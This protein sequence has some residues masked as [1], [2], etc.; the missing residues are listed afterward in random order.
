MSD[1]PA[2]TVSKSAA[3]G[4]DPA[5]SDGNAPNDFNV[6]TII[7][8]AS[9]EPAVQAINGGADETTPLKTGD[10]LGKFVIKRL[11]GRGGMGRVYLAHDPAIDREVAI[12]VLAEKFCQD[13]DVLERFRAEARSSGRLTHPNVVSVY[14]IGEDDCNAY[15]AMEYVEGGSVQ[16]LLRDGK[17]I[18]P[19]R[20]TEILAD[21]CAGLVAAH[22]EGMIHR[23]IKPANLLL[24]DD[25]GVKVADFGLARRPKS[26]DPRLTHA[27]HIV[28]TPYY[29]SPEQCGGGE[30]DARSDIYSMGAT[31]HTLLTGHAPFGP[32]RSAMDVIAAHMY[33]PRPLAHEEVTGVP[34]ICTRIVHRAMAKNPEDRYQTAQDLLTDAEALLAAFRD[35]DVQSRQADE[36]GGINSVLLPVQS[37]MAG[38]APAELPLRSASW[39]APEIAATGGV[40]EGGAGAR[41]TAAG[42]RPANAVSPGLSTP[43][44]SAAVPPRKTHAGGST[45]N[46][47]AGG[48]R[49]LTDAEVSQLAVARPHTGDPRR[50][51]VYSLHEGAVAL[52]WPPDIRRDEVDELKSWLKLIVAKM[53]RAA[54]DGQ[55][56]L[57]GNAP[58]QVSDRI[59]DGKPAANPGHRSPGPPEDSSDEPAETEELDRGDLASDR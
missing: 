10:K 55:G 43:A 46:P 56:E 49:F 44:A 7:P 13:E 34:E 54:S 9:P 42:G 20:A 1:E 21:A 47:D 51:D 27:A 38:Q 24:D 45:V 35:P 36:P 4:D 52:L 19:G 37:M 18:P 23:D 39:S 33:E 25:G 14:E 29:M 22:E 8:P 58:N 3:P 2:S 41:N 28:G 5:K 26:A 12:K 11:I 6:T 50:R 59:K 32:S 31:Y 30:M 53:E 16:E 17:P 57:S 40:G 48:T 15:L